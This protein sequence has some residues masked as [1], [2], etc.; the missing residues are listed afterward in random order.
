MRSAFCIAML[1]LVA[2]ASNL[3]A[4]SSV[5]IIRG[6]VT[7]PDGK[8]L[9]GVTVNVQSLTDE[10]T[11]STRSGNDGR[12]TVLFA[13]GDGDYMMTFLAI[14]MMPSS[15]EVQKT[16]DDDAV[17]VANAKMQAAPTQLDAVRVNGTR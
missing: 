13:G 16:S 10:T 4:Q 1:A 7:G 5:D 17:I 6:R 11:R 15:F 3:S 9:A 12:F 2:A 14:G 8:P